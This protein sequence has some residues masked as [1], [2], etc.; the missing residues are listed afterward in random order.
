MKSIAAW[1]SNS[2]TAGESVNYG[3]YQVIEEIGQGS[4][5]LVFR[6]HDPQ[7]DREVALKVLRRDRI[8]GEEFVN[9]FLK[10]ARVIGPAVSSQHRDGL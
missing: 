10:E 7:I 5:G 2:A 1:N 4:M 9:R 3:R 6:A 8:T